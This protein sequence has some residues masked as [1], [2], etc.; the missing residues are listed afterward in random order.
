MIKQR[1]KGCEICV[2]Q[3]GQAARRVCDEKTLVDVINKFGVVNDVDTMIGEGCWWG[4]WVRMDI[5]VSEY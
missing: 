5:Y 4:R 3:V 2:E 1:M